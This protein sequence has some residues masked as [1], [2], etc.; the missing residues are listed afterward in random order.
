M[1]QLRDL[2]AVIRQMGLFHFIR[3][4]W[5][6]VS[7][8]NLFTW[9]SAL[10]YSWLFALFPFFLVLLSL[11]PMLP[12]N[13]RVEA[14]EQINFAIIQLPREARVTL[15]QYVDPRLNEIL[16]EKPK[17]ITWVWTLGLLATLWAASGGVAMTMSAMD[18]A[19]DV[20][21][22]RPIYKQRPLAVG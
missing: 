12:H 20:Q 18:R 14:K 11:I 21:R 5:F 10:A 9:A 8:D 6:E 13:W 3:K 19:Y 22:A 4:V 1:A 17:A 16:F 15:K 7:D 2:P